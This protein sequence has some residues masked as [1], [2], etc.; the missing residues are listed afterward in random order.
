MMI[1]NFRLILAFLSLALSASTYLGKSIDGK[2]EA[3]K[4]N[5]RRELRV[6][7]NDMNENGAKHFVHRKLGANRKGK[8]G[9]I[10]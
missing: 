8:R 9:R 10:D 6:K 1:S 5:E 3:R 7:H 2:T 4:L